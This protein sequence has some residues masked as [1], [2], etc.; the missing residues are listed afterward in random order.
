MTDIPHKLNIVVRENN[1]I[2]I[3]ITSESNINMEIPTPK[4]YLTIA[5]KKWEN[6][7]DN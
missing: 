3:Q 6:T 2:I 1:G 7:N 5:Y 4:G